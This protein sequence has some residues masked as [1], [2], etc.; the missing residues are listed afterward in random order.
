[1]RIS[2]GDRRNDDYSFF[3]YPL[4]SHFSIKSLSG[5]G[6]ETFTNSGEKKK[7]AKI[8]LKSSSRTFKAFTRGST[9]EAELAVPVLVA[10]VRQQPLTSCHLQMCLVFFLGFFSVCSVGFVRFFLKRILTDLKMNSK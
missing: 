5:H 3:R 10:D 2:Q 7:I 4:H 8:T 1:M 6:V 9:E